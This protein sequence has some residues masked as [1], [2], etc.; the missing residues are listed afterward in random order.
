MKEGFTL[1]QWIR[2]VKEK[3]ASMDALVVSLQKYGAR[4]EPD[5]ESR[6]IAAL[7]YR[8]V[9]LFSEDVVVTIGIILMDYQTDSD[10]V[11]ETMTTLPV[12][13]THR[14]F[15]SRAITEILQWARDSGFK[16]VRATQV[17]G[18]DNESFWKKNGFAQQKEPNPCNDFVCRLP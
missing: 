3:K 8:V 10:V 14:G 15:G 18:G 12:A 1:S 17:T 16:E 4:V 2:E 6:D 5:E 11:I 13:G 9:F 7:H